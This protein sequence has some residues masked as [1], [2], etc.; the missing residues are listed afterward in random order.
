MSEEAREL[1]PFQKRNPA[2]EQVTDQ[3]PESDSRPIYPFVKSRPIQAAPAPPLLDDSDTEG[4]ADEF[5][6][7]EVPDPKDESAAASVAS[8]E[9]QRLTAP[10]VLETTVPMLVGKDSSK[11]KENENSLQSS[12]SETSLGKPTPPASVPLPPTSGPI[13][14]K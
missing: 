5:D 3:Q 6:D 11:D 1:T 10:V 4:G 7:L 14:P 2:M 12:S 9:S 8:L 13:Q